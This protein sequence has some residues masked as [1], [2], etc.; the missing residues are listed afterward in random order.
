MGN[1]VFLYSVVYIYTSS[2]SNN[3]ETNIAIV[4]VVLLHFKT[5][6]EINENTYMY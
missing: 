6:P 3:N 1:Y 2:L 4:G 5:N